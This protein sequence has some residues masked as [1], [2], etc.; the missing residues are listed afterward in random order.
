MWPSKNIVFQLFVGSSLTLFSC[1]PGKPVDR[2]A[3]KEEMEA[4]ELRHITDAEIAAKGEELGKAIVDAS[5]N[6]LMNALK[7]AIVEQGIDGAIKYCNLNALNLVKGLEDSLGVSI[8]RVTDRPRN[9]ND[10]LSSSDQLIWEAYEY[11]P[12]NAEAQIQAL[13]E[14][15]L[16]LTKPIKI[17][18]GLCLN[19][20][21]VVGETLTTE[22]NTLIKQLYPDD[23][24]TGYLGGDLRGMWKV[25]L[26]KKSIVKHM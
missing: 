23:Q 10:T 8:S 11:T 12:E 20:H 21:G 5:Q 4:R 14:D 7:E 3:I 19:C 18:T 15:H 2:S 1:Q 17:G 22:N 6:A 9:P 13:D 26:P 16:I 25:I 24:A